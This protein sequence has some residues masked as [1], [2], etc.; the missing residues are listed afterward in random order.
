[1]GNATLQEWDLWF[2][3]AAANGL[4]FARCQ[5]DPVEALLVHSAPQF[6]SVTV[7]DSQG[8]PVASGKDLPATSDTPITRLK[9]S[10][11]G[12]EDCALIT[13]EDIWPS[14]NDMG[15]VVIF[16]GG[17]AGILKSWW[18]APDHSEWR[19]QVELYNHR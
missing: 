19:W 4:P 5:I 12:T 8:H 14:E 10:G 1:M 3:K 7:R 18:N 11:N 9:I 16:P 15:S 17:E 6:L 2:P 13:R